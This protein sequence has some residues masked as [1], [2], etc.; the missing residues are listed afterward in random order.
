MHRAMTRNKSFKPNALCSTNH[1][2]GQA[3]P[4]AGSAT[5]QVPGIQANSD[6]A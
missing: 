2:A 5:C 6:T 1:M 4:V 3:F